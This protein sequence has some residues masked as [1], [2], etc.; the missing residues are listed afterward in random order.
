MEH[1]HDAVDLPAVMERLGGDEELLRELAALYVE[2]E[3]RLLAA[4]AEAI[5][6]GDAD[7][8]RRAAHTLKGAVS[9]FCAPRAHAAAQALETAGRDGQLAAAPALLDALRKEL[10]LVRAALTPFLA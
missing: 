2:D 7:A 6:R 9:N 1:S 3:G 10:T 4:M 5:E 8:L